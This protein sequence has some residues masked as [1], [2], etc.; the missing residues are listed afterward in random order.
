MDINF[1][2]YKIFYFVAELGS[3]SRAAKKL[4][5]SQPA[6][7][8]AVKQLE[9]NLSCSLFVRGSRGV[10]LTNEGELLYTYVKKGCEM[11]LGGEEKLRQV[12][13][14]ESGE[15]KIGA[16]D[17]T[18]KYFL[19]PYLERFHERYPKIKVSVTNAPTPE[20]LSYLMDGTIDFGIISGP[21]DVGRA[22]KTI[23]VKEINDI[24]VAGNRFEKLQDRKLSY[25]DLI[26]MPVILLE[27]NTTTRK[28]LDDFLKEMDIELIPEFE[29]ATSDMIVEFAMRNLGIGCVVENFARDYI[30]NGRLFKL[31]FD[32]KIPPRNI[33][34]AVNTKVPLSNAASRL[35]ESLIKI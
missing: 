1:E 30:E 16:S 5:V 25:S 23:P 10:K 33:Y 2:Y 6:V 17:M 29:I 24:F 4:C 31:E 7:S 28:Y 19:L 15:I 18:L 11:I 14:L 27:K 34:L 3:L 26:E 8:Q 21:A 20:T 32:K 9:E 22:I 12:L 35:M 13:E